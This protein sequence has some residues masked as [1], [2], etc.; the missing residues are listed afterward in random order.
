MMIRSDGSENE[1]REL[2]QRLATGESQLKES[3]RHAEELIVC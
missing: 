3:E 1:V 2:Q